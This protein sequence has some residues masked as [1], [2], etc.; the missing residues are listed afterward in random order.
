MSGL[1]QPTIIGNLTECSQS[2]MF[3]HANRESTM[4]LVRIR[5]G[6]SKDVGSATVKTSSGFVKLNNGERFKSGDFVNIYQKKG[7]EQSPPSA[8]IEV[9]Q[10]GEFPPPEVSGHLYQCSKVI[11]LIGMRSGVKIDLLDGSSIIGSGEADHGNMAFITSDSGLPD[12][13]KKLYA[14]QYDCSTPPTPIGTP[15]YLGVVEANPLVNPHGTLTYPKIIS[16]LYEC[17]RS[18]KLTDVVPGMMIYIEGPGFSVETVHTG[19]TSYDV[20]LPVNLV[21]KQNIK[22]HQEGGKSCELISNSFVYTVGPFQKP[23]TP[24]LKPIVCGTIGYLSASNLKKGADV[25]IKVTDTSGQTRLYSA[26]ASCSE[27]DIPVPNMPDGAT[28]WI[29]QIECNDEKDENWSAWSNPQTVNIVTGIGQFRIVRDLIQCQDTIQVENLSPLGGTLNVTSKK[30]GDISIPVHVD[31]NPMFLNVSPK[32]VA[33]DVIT[34]KHDVCGYSARDTESV[35]NLEGI[36][37]GNIVGPPYDGNTSVEVTNITSGAYVELRDGTKV[38][39]TGTTP[40]NNSK[41]KTTMI[42]SGFGTLKN[43]Q[44]LTVYIRHCGMEATSPEVTVEYPK[45][46]LLQLIPD[47]A[48]KG[49][50]SLDLTLQGKNFRPG[51]KIS[52]GGLDIIPNSIS[53]NQISAKLLSNHLSVKKF[54]PVVVINPDLKQSNP[55]NFSVN[56]PSPINAELRIAIGDGWGTLNAVIYSATFKVTT[57]HSPPKEEFEDAKR[58][59]NG[60]FAAVYNRPGYPT[61]DYYVYVSNVVVQIL[62][63]DGTVINT[64][65]GAGPKS[66]GQDSP[67]ID[68]WSQGVHQLETFNVHLRG[69]DIVICLP[70]ALC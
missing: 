18:V 31:R 70:G 13:G 39:Q 59:P 64:M 53:F 56:D 44:Q 66:G 61:G 7:T 37:A 11:S 26:V 49:T 12:V 36:S 22:I 67:A 23:I 32:L 28:V 46:E 35:L 62:D 43:G 30:I 48:D 20:E 50:N 45:P 63:T 16:G 10:N 68:K 29:R 8:T 1:C 19:Q 40:L 21:E 6:I 51:A 27:D 34:V 33:G 25:Q 2:V 24:V 69:T 57:P 55:I 15:T 42:F 9:Q 17:S 41:G 38:L 47:H 52:W 58:Q 60:E 14:Q 3:D 4:I 5:N 65:V 54:V